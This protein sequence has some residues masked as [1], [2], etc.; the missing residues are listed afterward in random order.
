MITLPHYSKN[1]GTSSELVSN[2]LTETMIALDSFQEEFEAI[3]FNARDYSSAA[4][5]AATAERSAI[6]KKLQEIRSY[7]EAHLDAALDA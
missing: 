3:E 2:Q 5:T 6:F 7:L 1:S 4:F